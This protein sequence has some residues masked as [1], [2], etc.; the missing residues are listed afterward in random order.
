V[1]AKDIKITPKLNNLNI[2]ILFPSISAVLK[3]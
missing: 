2:S 1:A 3:K